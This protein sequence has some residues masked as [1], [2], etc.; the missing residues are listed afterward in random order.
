MNVRKTVLQWSYEPKEFFEEPVT[1]ENDAFHVLIA[2]GSCSVSL[3]A[4]ADP[5]PEALRTN[6]EKLVKTLFLTNQPN[7]HQK[8]SISNTTIVQTTEVSSLGRRC[9]DKYP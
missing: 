9:A 8:Y 1:L 6:A 5:V 3:K 7:N 4:P 2:E